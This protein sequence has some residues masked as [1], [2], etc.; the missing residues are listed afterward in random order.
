MKKVNFISNNHDETMKIGYDLSK[1]INPPYAIGLIGDLA[2]G[3]TT[4]VKG[5]RLTKNYLLQQQELSRG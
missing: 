4:F 3:K 1:Q 2:A 5:F